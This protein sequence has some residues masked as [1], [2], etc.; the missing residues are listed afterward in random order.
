VL[1]IFTPIYNRDVKHK[2]NMHITSTKPG[3]GK[4]KE[5]ENI[6]NRKT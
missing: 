6:K 3:H 5:Q 1:K 2:F 4:H